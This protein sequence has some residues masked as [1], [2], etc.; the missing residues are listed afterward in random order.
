[1]TF[2]GWIDVLQSGAIVFL[3]LAIIFVNKRLNS[4]R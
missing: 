1:M 4:P 2:Q 3:A